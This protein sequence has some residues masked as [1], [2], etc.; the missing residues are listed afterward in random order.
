VTFIKG[1]SGNPLGRPKNKPLSSQLSSLKSSEDIEQQ[2]F[3]PVVS[4]HFSLQ[5]PEL[6]Q[7]A[8]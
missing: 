7:K 5:P 6:E 1:Q 2:E 8:Q 3:K 4:Q